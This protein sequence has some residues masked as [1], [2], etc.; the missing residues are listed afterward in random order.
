MYLP[1]KVIRS[2]ESDLSEFQ[3]NTRGVAE[4]DS[5]ASKT[6]GV[7]VFNEKIIQL[8]GLHVLENNS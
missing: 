3:R 2:L 6:D 5:F 1:S 4:Q 7:V 8:Q